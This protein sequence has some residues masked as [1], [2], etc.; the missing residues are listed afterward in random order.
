[1]DDGGP[2]LIRDEQGGE[3]GRTDDGDRGRGG[4]GFLPSSSIYLSFSG[5]SSCF[6]SV[7]Y[8]IQY[9]LLIWSPGRLFSILT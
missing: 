2:K 1:M 8:S 7:F 3:N 5:S 6:F 4:K 9:R